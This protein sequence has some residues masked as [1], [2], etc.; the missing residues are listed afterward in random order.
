[1]KAIIVV[2]TCLLAYT[3]M[4]KAQNVGI[5]TSNPTR[6]KLE[7][8]GSVGATAAIFGGD[9][10]GISLQSN[11]PTVGFNQ[12][13]NNGHRYMA[14]GYAAHQF[15]DPNL[16]YIAFDIFQ[17]G[18]ANAL[19]STSRRPLS[20]DHSGSVFLGDGQSR[21]YVNRFTNAG[22]FPATVQINQVEGRGLSIVDPVSGS[23]WQ[24]NVVVGGGPSFLELEFNGIL[25]GIFKSETGEYLTFSDSRLKNNIRTLPSA[26]EKL[27]QLTPVEY[28]MK[29]NN[30]RRE[31]TIGFIA[32]DVQKLFPELVFVIPGKLLP[33]NGEDL[34]ALNYNGFG[35]LAIKAIQDQQQIIN[36]MKQEHAHLLKTIQTLSNRL[37]KIEQELA[38]DNH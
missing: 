19:A 7:V 5:G 1:M 25:K 13:Y 16:G 14:R 6:A 29:N 15:L 12:Y 31:K 20:L 27:M 24:W 10:T 34:Y 2:I 33:R 18:N 23:R 32:Q 11:W 17:P 36:D 9:T 35:V 22:A 8:H 21:I 37:E 4:L 26:L 38:K 28:E 3:K 30:P